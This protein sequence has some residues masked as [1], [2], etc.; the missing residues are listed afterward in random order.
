MIT[1]IQHADIYAPMPLGILDVLLSDGHIAAI[2][3]HLKVDLPSHCLEVI[4]AEGL[5]LAPGF[6]DAL[7]HFL[8]GGGEA[9]FGS[10]T[11]ELMFDEVASS[12]VTT[13]VGALGTDSVTRSPEQLLGKAR[14][15]S[16]HGVTTYCYTG[17]YHLPLKTIT[18]SVERD[19]MIIPEMIGI[20]EVAISDHRASHAP[21]HDLA[22]QVS[23]ARVGGMLAGKRGISFF[24]VGDAPGK[25]APLRGLLEATD[26]PIDQFYPTHC[27]RNA[28]LFADA[29]AFLAQ[30]G[31]IDLTTSTLP[32]Y[33]QKG[34]VNCGAALAQAVEAG[35]NWRRLS[36]SSDANASLPLFDERGSTIKVECGRI[37]SLY[38]A[39]REAVQHY[40]VP[41]EIALSSI[42]QNPADI[43]GLKHKG[44]V[45]QGSD[46]DLVL[47]DPKT[48]DLH[49]VIAK[50]RSI[51]LRSAES[52]LD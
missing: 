4:D 22:Q 35:L 9:G 16:A 32:E 48:L 5:I 18:G 36:F 42:T 31:A 46:A 3:P 45:T 37:A 34:E 28:D 44:R 25:L 52:D 2:G 11:P 10:R 26:I 7:V 30:G 15:L 1:L 33:V 17:S 50:G 29:L 43:L 21:L 19:L 23:Q 41:L 13:L 8:G 24:H 12:G 14:E 40:G 27:N 47:I 49:R 20:G 39:C 51:W 38:E 6:V